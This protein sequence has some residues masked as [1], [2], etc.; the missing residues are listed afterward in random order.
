MEAIELMGKEVLPEFIE[1]DEKAVADKAKR[2]EPVLEK[3][4]ARRQKSTAPVFDE[5]YSFGGLPTGRGGKFTAT[6]IPEAMAEMN[7]GRVQAAQL[8]KEE[9]ERGQS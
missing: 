9:R 6:E 4:E 2:L 7:E 8:A 1:R 3:L 5:S